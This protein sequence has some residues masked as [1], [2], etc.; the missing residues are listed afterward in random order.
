MKGG[1]KVRNSNMVPRGSQSDLCDSFKYLLDSCFNWA[2][3]CFSVAKYTWVYLTIYNQWHRTISARTSRCKLSTGFYVHLGLISLVLELHNTF[4]L[5]RFVL[6]SWE[7][8]RL[9]TQNSMSH[10]HTSSEAITT[11]YSSQGNG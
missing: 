6:N 8:Q 5:W 9:L 1:Q 4:L 3:C 7:V 11:A 2:L 10:D